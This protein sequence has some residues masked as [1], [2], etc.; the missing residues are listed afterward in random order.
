MRAM[1]LA[2]LIITA[3]LPLAL[4]FQES[5]LSQEKSAE[6]GEVAAL[7]LTARSQGFPFPNLRATIWRMEK[8]H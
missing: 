4:L 2:V 8:S 3:S 6:E 7:H 5:P 1:E